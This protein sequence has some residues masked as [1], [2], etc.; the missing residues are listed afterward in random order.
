MILE[1]NH[2]HTI[3][4]TSNTRRTHRLQDT[5]E[6]TSREMRK[7]QVAKAR[8][9]SCTCSIIPAAVVLALYS[10]YELIINYPFPPLCTPAVIIET[11]DDPVQDTLW[12]SLVFHHLITTRSE[13][14]S[15]KR[16]TSTTF[17]TRFSDS[18]RQAHLSRSQELVCSLRITSILFRSSNEYGTTACL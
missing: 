2:S 14:R 4:L 10:G 17:C 8:L 1:Q 3:S 18:S 7:E 6:S 12:W 9:S 16:Q 13:A 15:R 5:H 11:F